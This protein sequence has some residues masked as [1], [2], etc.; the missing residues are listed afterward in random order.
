MSADPFYLNRPVHLAR[1]DVFYTEAADSIRQL[2]SSKEPAVQRLIA[3]KALYLLRESRRHAQAANLSEQTSPQSILFVDFLDTAVDNTQSIARMLRRQTVVGE[4]GNPLDRFLGSTDTSSKM[5]GHY[6][7]CAGLVL[8]GLLNIIR[9]AEKP[10]HEL[11]Q[12]S[13]AIMSPTDKARY[14]KA[15]KQFSLLADGEAEAAVGP[16][17]KP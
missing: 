11:Q 8:K 12:A 9:D 16:F 1:R 10:L 6:H 15:Y 5:H 17:A 2:S 14:E 3:E 4:S 13:L 7:R